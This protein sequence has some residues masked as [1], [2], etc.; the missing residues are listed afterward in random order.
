[1][2]LA[3]NSAAEFD[4]SDKSN[5]PFG[6]EFPFFGE[7]YDRF[8]V[9]SNG[10]ITF[11]QSDSRVLLSTDDFF[12]APRIAPFASDLNPSRGGTVIVKVLTGQLLVSIC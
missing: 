12:S 4:S 9:S 6:F 7:V 3:D 5:N 2:N 11:G 8:Y 10:Y 1:M